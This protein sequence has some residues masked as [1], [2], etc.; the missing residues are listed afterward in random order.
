M[1]EEI[2]TLRPSF[3]DIGQ[4]GKN[5]LE[6]AHFLL[7]PVPYEYTV[8]Y[9]TGT[10]EGPAS[11]I[12]ASHHVE[13][14][15]EELN[16]E[17]WKESG[18]HTLPAHSFRQPP[19]TFIHG[20][21]DH[22]RKVWR[23]GAFLFT[24][25]GEHSITLAPVEV[26]AERT[27]GLSIL[28]LDAHADLRDEYAGSP[29]NHA[30]V[31]RRSMD[32]A[33]VVQVGIR[34]VSEDEVHYCNS[35]KVRTFLMQEHRDI[36]SLIPQ[37]LEALTEDVYVT[38]DVDGLDPSVIPGTGTPVPGGLGWWETL[39]LLREVCRTKN[40]VAAD[41]VELAPI[42]GTVVSEYAAARLAYKMMGYVTA[43]RLG[44]LRPGSRARVP[45]G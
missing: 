37:V 42:E 43:R 7:L 31:M 23:P 1:T 35:E 45:G 8:S 9:G 39:D 24:I 6:N 27:K 4:T 5:S 38:I 2:P 29:F 20:L 15:D 21:R 12:Q 14:L 10:R 3:L 13:L 32:V 18:I 36:P 11:L 26:A 16:F 30:C 19:E 41:I 17:P 40:V 25:G 33:P 28:Q 44:K 34:C 22:I